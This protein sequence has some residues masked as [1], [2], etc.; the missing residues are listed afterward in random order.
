[1]TCGTCYGQKNPVAYSLQG[2][3]RALEKF[4]KNVEKIDK[5]L[6]ETVLECLKCSVRVAKWVKAFYGSKY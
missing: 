1:M 2:S 6:P 5:D 3:Q 4:Q